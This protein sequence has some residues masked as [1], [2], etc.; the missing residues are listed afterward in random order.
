M[1]EVLNVLLLVWALVAFPFG[2]WFGRVGI[3]WLVDRG[4]WPV[5]RNLR[6]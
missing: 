1:N 6:D 4:W 5:P 2:V 3:P